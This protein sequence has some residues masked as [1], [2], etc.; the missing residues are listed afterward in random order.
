MN[1]VLQRCNKVLQRCAEHEQRDN[2]YPAQFPDWFENGNILIRGMIKDGL[3]KE[4]SRWSGAGQIAVRL[5]DKG[6]SEIQ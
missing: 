2:F 4:D 5:T 3:L 1:K 6:R